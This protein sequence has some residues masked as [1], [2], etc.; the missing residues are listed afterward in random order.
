[1]ET[2]VQVWWREFARSRAPHLRER[3]IHHYSELPRRAVDRLQINT[4]GCVSKDDLLGHAHIGLIDAVERFDPAHGVPFEGFA[5]PRIRGAVLDA[6]RRLDW[7]PRSL[8]ADE[9][10]LRRAHEAL[11]AALGR[12]PTRA[13]LARELR[14]SA[15]ELDTLQSRLSRSAMVSLDDL[16]TGG[17]ESTPLGELT[18]DDRQEDPY[19]KQEASA[20][21]KALV[22]AIQRLPEREK[23]VVSLYYYQ[24]LTLKEIGSR[25]QVTEQ[26]VSQL[27][28]RAMSRLSQRLT[29]QRDLFAALIA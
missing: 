17:A 4:W 24:Q 9:S 25:L 20:A 12:T 2:Q 27:H 7:A 8:R 11:E 14:M 1:M 19:Q 23:N 28:A 5:A 21:R 26:R 10:R 6:L 29:H 13:E 3:L 22:D 18:A 15:E 16:V